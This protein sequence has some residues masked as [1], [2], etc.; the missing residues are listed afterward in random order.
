MPEGLDL[1]RRAYHDSIG[2]FA[3][4]ADKL[5]LHS[6]LPTLDHMR[7]ET[8]RWLRVTHR[9]EGVERHHSQISPGCPAQASEIHDVE[10]LPGPTRDR[11]EYSGTDGLQGPTLSGSCDPLSR[12]CRV[13][14][15]PARSR[16]G[17]E[18]S[19]AGPCKERHGARQSR[20]HHVGPTGSRPR[21]SSSDVPGRD[22]PIQ[23]RR[24]SVAQPGRIRA[25]PTPVAGSRVARAGWPGLALAHRLGR[26]GRDSLDFPSG[27]AAAFLRAR[28]IV[29]VPSKLSDHNKWGPS[30]R[31]SSPR[32]P[33]AQR[34]E[35]IRGN[36]RSGSRVQRKS[37]PRFSR[38][39]VVR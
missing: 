15:P 39:L 38:E 9:R 28:C 35:T 7:F 10:K 2:L 8:K 21:R 31:S 20:E 19:R 11:D 22:R 17:L 27:W 4:L 12:S 24:W 36:D 3:S 14:G 33:L 1:V 23:R 13:T 37:R 25:G 18:E 29:T 32:M 30:S 16:F 34:Q 5:L 6:A 26:L